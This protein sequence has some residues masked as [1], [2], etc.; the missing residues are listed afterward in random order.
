M[1]SRTTRLLVPLLSLFAF[2]SLVSAESVKGIPVTVLARREVTL[3]G[4]SITYLLIR[5]PSLTPPPASPPAP[6]TSPSAE[7]LAAQ[8]LHDAKTYVNLGMGAIVYAGPPTVTELS[9]NLPDGRRFRAFSS[10]DF[11]HLSQLTELET[12]TTIYGWGTLVS[13][14]DPAELPT[15]V[16]E[17]LSAAPGA[18][19]LFEGTE[20]DAQANESMLGALDYLHAYYQLHEATLVAATASRKAEAAEWERQAAEAAARPRHEKIYFWKVQ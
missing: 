3:A 17:A 18:Q 6:V 10:V 5:P 2:S 16:R 15:G 11:T 4:G 13:E 1:P 20:A 9:W 12:A 19:Y 8:A 14:G 7:E